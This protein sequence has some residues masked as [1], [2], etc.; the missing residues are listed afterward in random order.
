MACSHQSVFKEKAVKCVTLVIGNQDYMDILKNPINDAKGM[1]KVLKSI[2]FEVILRLDVTLAQLDE[3]L[4]VLRTKNEPNSTMIFIYFS[5][6]FFPKMSFFALI[7]PAWEC[8]RELD[9]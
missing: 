9:L 4:A 8:I 6:D 1:A 5:V 2:S 3:N 7:T